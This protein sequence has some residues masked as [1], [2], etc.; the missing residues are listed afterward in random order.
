[1]ILVI[2]NYDSFVFNLARYVVELGQ[3]VQVVRN[4]AFS[5]EKIEQLKPAAIIISPGPRG[6][7]EAGLSLAVIQ[8]FAGQIPILGVCL[9][10]QAIGLAFGGQ[11]VRSPEPRHGKTTEI[12]HDG[13]GL[14]EG[15]PN[16]FPAGRYHSL[17][18][19]RD[20]L[21][22][23]LVVT[24]WTKDGLV[25]GL[26]HTRHE[27]YGWQFHSESI[28]TPCGLQ[29]MSAFLKRVDSSPVGEC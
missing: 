11:I 25:M 22:A 21:P 27:I 26:K 9:G 17:L 13:Q 20:S 7:A 6:P 1:M 23:E 5:L 2:D 4:D 28:L 15:M 12:Y 8:R 29:L 16:P 19:E 3:A 24:A 18:V 10:H 14:F